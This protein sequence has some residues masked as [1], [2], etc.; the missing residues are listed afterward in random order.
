MVQFGSECLPGRA[1]GPSP[2]DVLGQPGALGY[3]QES[4][5]GGS[6]VFPLQLYHSDCFP[7]CSF[8]FISM[9][10]IHFCY[11]LHGR[12]SHPQGICGRLATQPQL[13]SRCP[14]CQCTLPVPIGVAVH[15]SLQA[16][17]L[18]SLIKVLEKVFIKVSPSQ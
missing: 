14:G 3:A 13:H 5:G 6:L 10:N 2:E 1:G 9:K 8:I 17:I 16:I 7:K 4:G 11:N 15:V 18:H 12:A